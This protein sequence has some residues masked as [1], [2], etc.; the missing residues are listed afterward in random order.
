VLRVSEHLY[1]ERRAY[2]G[3]DVEKGALV[4]SGG[5]SFP[6]NTVLGAGTDSAAKLVELFFDITWPPSMIGFCEVS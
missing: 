5:K 1:I 4:A 3:A 2:S 6:G